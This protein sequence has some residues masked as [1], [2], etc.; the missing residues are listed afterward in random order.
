MTKPK[1]AENRRADR[2][3][4]RLL[5]N[6]LRLQADLLDEANDG[7]SSLILGRMLL[8]ILSILGKRSL[9]GAKREA[10]ANHF[11]D[12]AIIGGG[13]RA[14][15]LGRAN[16][17]RAI[18]LVGSF[19]IEELAKRIAWGEGRSGITIEDEKFPA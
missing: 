12:C 1:S 11:A 7:R 16:N 9:N 13:P 2:A 17:Q 15:E 10:L 4:R 6:Q 18:H 8:I 5:F 3:R 14:V 19:S